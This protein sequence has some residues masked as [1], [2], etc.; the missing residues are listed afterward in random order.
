MI[1]NKLGGGAGAGRD[2][3]SAY[4]STALF[5]PERNQDRNSYKAG[6]WRQELTQR[7]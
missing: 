2:F 1:K 4:T 3:Y 5:I 6:T 7:A